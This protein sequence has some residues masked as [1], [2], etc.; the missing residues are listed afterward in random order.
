[1]MAST[2]RGARRGWAGGRRTAVVAVV[3]C[4]LAVMCG[5]ARG[6]GGSAVASFDRRGPDGEVMELSETNF[7]E[8]VGR[9]APVLVKVY[10]SWCKH[11]VALAPTWEEVARELEGELHVGSVEGPKNRILLRRIGVK[12]YPMIVLFKNGKMYEYES[13]D[14]S[15]EAIVSFARKDYRKVRS[16]AFFHAVWF[17][18]LLRSLYAVPMLGRRAYEYLHD[19]L[20]LSNVSILFLTLCVPVTAGMFAIFVADMFIVRHVLRETRQMYQQNGGPARPHAD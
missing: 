15:V 11:C 19:T 12:A 9:G 5:A 13:G 10:A 17:S 1:M 3:A 14:R 2:S 7:D 18:K 6:E 16:R 4:A 8:T 20:K